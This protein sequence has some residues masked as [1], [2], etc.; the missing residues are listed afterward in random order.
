MDA[1]ASQTI[2]DG[3]GPLLM[4]YITLMAALFVLILL[5][6]IDLGTLWQHDELLTA[7]RAREMIVRGD[8]LAV[9]RNFA[10][11]FKKPPLQY[12]LC[13]VALRLLPEHRE[14]A[15]RLPSLL[16]GALCLLATAWSARACFPE[17]SDST[18][19]TR[20]VLALAGCGYFIHM[21]RVALLDT[22]AA[23]HLTLAV[24]GCQ[25]ARRDARWH[26]FV[27]LQCVLGA[28]QKAPYAFAAWGI[29]LLLRAWRKAEDSLPPRGR[30]HLVGALAVSALAASGW[31]VLQ[32]IRFGGEAL[33]AAGQQ[34]TATLLRA[35]DDA[36]AVFRPYLYWFW[37]ARDWAIPGLC[38]PLAA[39]SVFFRKSTRDDSRLVECVAVCLIFGAVI[40]A[41][42]Y[43]AERYLIV[44]T[45]LLAIL[46]VRWLGEMAARLPWTMPDAWRR[47]LP[48]LALTS[49]APVALFHYSAPRPLKRTCSPP[50]A[51]WAATCALPK[52]S[53]SA[54]E[55]TPP[56]TPGISFPSMPP[57]TGPCG[58]GQWRKSTSGWRRQRVRRGPAGGCADDGN[59]SRCNGIS[60][61]CWGFPPRRIGSCGALR[62][63]RQPLRRLSSRLEFK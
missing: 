47:W 34:Q 12:W 46:S 48:A 23:F 29:I 44:I 40:A 55:R 28:W 45:P 26:W 1:P 33:F 57:S 54:G 10:P 53:S 15:V 38:T 6:R 16:Y 22:G 5:P 24:G 3:Q 50:R 60:P 9:T 17:E 32:G 59:G 25:L 41:L 7:N 30:V 11:D 19:A 20:A 63:L 31:W 42:P 43:R 18:L 21:S 8:P 51:N 14:L 27:G 49:A 4:G 62:L 61:R 52:S 36:D 13:A 37:M 35:H 39:A 56:S 2:S 58:S